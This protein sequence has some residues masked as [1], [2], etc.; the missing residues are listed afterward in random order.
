M[1]KND[2]AYANVSPNFGSWRKEEKERETTNPYSLF[3]NMQEI[4]AFTHRKYGDAA[5]WWFYRHY[6]ED[7]Q[8][9]KGYRQQA[10]RA[11][12]KTD[13]EYYL[14]RAIDTT[15]RER[16]S[17]E[18]RLAEY[19]TLGINGLAGVIR[20]ILAGESPPQP[21]IDQW[22]AWGLAD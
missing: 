8:I 21:I 10:A 19:E 2:S 9:A 20:R 11:Q 17:L 22:T 14:N 16:A 5:I 1:P 15:D 18:T 3:N 12:S 7:N 6:G 13:R 4:E